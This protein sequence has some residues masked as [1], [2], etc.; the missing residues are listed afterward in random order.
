MTTVVYVWSPTGTSLGHSAIRIRDKYVSFGP[1]LDRTKSDLIHG[2]A[3]A[4]NYARSYQRDV[5]GSSGRHPKQYRFDS[6]DEDLMLRLVDG[7]EQRQ[8][9]YVTADFNCSTL[10]AGLLKYGSMKA[11][12]FAPRAP[13]PPIKDPVLILL[14]LASRMF[15]EVWT[16]AHIEKFALEL[17]GELV[18]R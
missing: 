3:V 16:P 11:P 7:F 15:R 14:A 18:G 13:I 1:Y 6:L 17:G 12:S 2:R 10:V 4:G 8:Y 5:D 9:E